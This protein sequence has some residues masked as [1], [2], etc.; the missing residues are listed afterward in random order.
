MN[1][2]EDMTH[3]LVEAEVR[4]WEDAEVNGVD[5][6]D[7][8]RIPARKGDL[9]CPIIRLKDGFI[10]NWVPGVSARVHYKV[11]DAGVYYLSNDG[12]SKIHQYKNWYVP[13]LLCVNANGY[14]DYIIFSVSEDGEIENWKAPHLHPKKWG[15]PGGD[16]SDDDDD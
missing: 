5:D 1:S 11:C 7:G 2:L 8:S 3:V 6:T 9:W 10:E 14:G 13:D 4:Y 15:E 12:A 16:F